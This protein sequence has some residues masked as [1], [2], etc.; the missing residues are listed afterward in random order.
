M[1]K[2]LIIEDGTCILTEMENNYLE[3]NLHVFSSLEVFSMDDI[4]SIAPHLILIDN[5]V[6]GKLGARFCT[7]LSADPFTN[8]IPMMLFSDHNYVHNITNSSHNH[9]YLCK[10]F[11]FARI[12]QTINPGV[13]RPEIMC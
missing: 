8:H 11:N 13:E 6:D 12:V 10:P 2:V 5:D 3:Y 7:E 9:Q 1:K 4:R